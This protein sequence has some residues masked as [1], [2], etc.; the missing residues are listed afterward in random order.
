MFFSTI[1][2]DTLISKTTYRYFQYIKSSLSVTTTNNYNLQKWHR[3]V[4][5]KIRS[6]NAEVDDISDG[7]T[8]VTFPLSTADAFRK[9]F[10][11]FQHSIYIRHHLT[12]K[13]TA[14]YL[15]SHIHGDL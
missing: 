5:Y 13:T 7:L 6:T 3:K 9:A 1:R 15:Y 11:L 8:S 10:D 4:T 14:K 2:Y 12:D